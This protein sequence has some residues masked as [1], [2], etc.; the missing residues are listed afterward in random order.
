[1][2]PQITFLQG[3]LAK[4]HF[5]FKK[6]R[7]KSKR[8]GVKSVERFQSVYAKAASL[9]NKVASKEPCFFGHQINRKVPSEAL[10]QYC[11]RSVYSVF[12]DVVFADTK[13]RLI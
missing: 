2:Q 4:V 13:S 1:M 3:K 7:R 8:K 9:T 5:G 6:L 10:R 12:L 11:Q